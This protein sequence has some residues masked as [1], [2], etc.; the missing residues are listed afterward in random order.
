MVL[1]EF[2]ITATTF[3]TCKHRNEDKDVFTVLKQMQAETRR[4]Y[5]AD[6][7]GMFREELRK[8]GYTE[9]RINKLPKTE[10]PKYPTMQGFDFDTECYDGE[11]LYYEIL[12][13][14]LEELEQGESEKEALGDEMKE[15]DMNPKQKEKMEEEGM[16]MRMC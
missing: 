16:G 3:Y 5:E 2:G 14:K 8:L 11:K 15:K 1:R 9:A 6:G 7:K 13:E 12:N 10:I 4:A